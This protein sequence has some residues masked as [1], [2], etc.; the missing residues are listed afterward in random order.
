[1]AYFKGAYHSKDVYSHIQSVV[2]YARLLG[3][4]IMVE[5][6]IPGID[7]PCALYCAY[8]SF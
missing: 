5:F 1:M 7:I 2:K 4:R 6:D 8:R 3:I